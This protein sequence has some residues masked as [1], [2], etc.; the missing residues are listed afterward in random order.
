MVASEREYAM[1]AAVLW[2]NGFEPVEGCAPVDVLRRGGIDVVCVS[3]ME[4]PSVEAAH[5]ISF[6]ADACVRDVDL[7]SFDL[8]VLPG[9]SLGV[10]NLSAC[11]PLR[12]AL[13]ARARENRPIAAICAAPMLLADLG[14]LEG[15]RATCYPGCEGNFPADAYV[16]GPGVVVDGNLVTAS[17]P[18]QAVDFGLAC[19][20]LLAGDDV[21]RSVAEGMLVA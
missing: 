10:E 3:V 12:H 13:L 7:D 20:K 4:T 11:E 17:G 16:K 1:K 21:A 8:L 9:G 15:R 19:L 6:V 14:I 18:G 2:G 5:G